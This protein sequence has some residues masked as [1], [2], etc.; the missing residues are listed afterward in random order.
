MVRAIGQ[1]QG[2]TGTSIQTEYAI[3]G[4]YFALGNNDVTTGV[5]KVQ[6]YLRT[7]PETNRPWWTITENCTNLIN[8]MGKLRWKTYSSRKMQFENNKQE[9]IH[10]KDDHAADS[11]RYFFSYLPDLTPQQQGLPPTEEDTVSIG[12][13]G[14]DP[15][16]L[17]ID[18]VL[19]KMY[20]NGPTEWSYKQSGDL[21]A[22]EYEG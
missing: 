5:A 10:K 17:R 12:N 13:T 8:E 9:Q 11:A 1:R 22:L 14:H 19:A 6:Q 2:V 15:N 3:R 4:L 16:V 21:A 18:D 7:N 20:Q